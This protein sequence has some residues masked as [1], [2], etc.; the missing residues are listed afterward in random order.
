MTESSLESSPSG[1]PEHP[2]LAAL[3]AIEGALGSVVQV[4]PSF[5]RTETKAEA[6]TRLARAEARM[7]ELRMR[8]MADA[9][10]VA[11]D[12]AARDVGGWYAHQT[13][14]DPATA[15][16]E[17][18]LA[19]ALD[20]RWTQVAEAMRAGDLCL[21]QARVIARSLTALAPWVEA[22]VLAEA[23][24]ALVELATDH[25]PRQ[26]AA[27]G[28]RI[29]TVVA[30]DL[31]DEIEALR[32]EAEEADVEDKI[33]LTVRHHA[34]GT[35]RG[36]FVLDKLGGTRLAVLLDAYTN[37][38]QHHH[39]TETTET[40][41]GPGGPGGPDGPCSAE[42]GSGQTDQAEPATS[43]SGPHPDPVERLPRGRTLGKAFCALLESLDP[44]ALPRHGGDQTLLQITI[45]LEDICKKLAAGT[46]LTTAAIPGT[47]SAETAVDRISASE[48]RRLACNARILPVVLGGK[49]EILDLGRD[50]RLFSP[51]QQRAMLL[52]DRT[53]RAEGCTIPGTWA[54]AHHWIPWGKLGDS[55]LDDGVLLCSHH[56]HRIHQET[57][58]RAERLPNGDVRFHRRR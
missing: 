46:I 18:A 23:Q 13:R 57:R 29:V 50:R 20:R 38:R 17:A 40:T 47:P 4:N 15:K 52:R 51:A 19:V 26:L 6:L 1:V 24:T 30:P 58:W 35:I 43:L 36:S 33:R 56:H 25:G 10:D 8:I 34:D 32:L 12:A 22:D 3:E 42:A 5:M 45:G 16:V 28:A 39:R 49:S 55:D 9:D 11:A 2:V 37:P 54:E 41:D 31:A 14:T 53:C 44:A 7:V 48:V 21:A 27:L